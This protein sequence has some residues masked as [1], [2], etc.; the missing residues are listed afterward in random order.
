M[1][2]RSRSSLRPTPAAGHSESSSS[3]SR[4]LLEEGEQSSADTNRTDQSS[5][6]FKE[7]EQIAISQTI[8]ALRRQKQRLL[9][10]QKKQAQQVVAVRFDAHQQQHNKCIDSNQK[11]KQRRRRAHPPKPEDAKPPR[12]RAGTATLRRPTT[13]PLPTDQ[14]G[15]APTT[16]AL[17]KVTFA[18]MNTV[19][20]FEVDADD[21]NSSRNTMDSFLAHYSSWWQGI[22]DVA[23]KPPVKIRAHEKPLAYTDKPIY[24]TTFEEIKFKNEHPKKSYVDRIRERTASLSAAM[25]PGNAASSRPREDMD[26]ARNRITSMVDPIQVRPSVVLDS[27]SKDRNLAAIISDDESW[28]SSS[29]FSFSTFLG[30]QT[31]SNTVN[32]CSLCSPVIPIENQVYF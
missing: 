11:A 23:D 21:D 30:S 19:N 25:S 8:Q 28:K 27:A 13:K 15:I 2:F 3:G 4:I 9:D 29:S 17:R 20:T 32:P 26:L 10:Q 6:T 31:T 24:P 7:Q 16:N 22:R 5:L 12:R 14:E 18:Q 1:K